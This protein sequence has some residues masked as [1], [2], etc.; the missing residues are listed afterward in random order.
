MGGEEEE[1]C[2]LEQELQIKNHWKDLLRE[3]GLS[4]HHRAQAPCDC[5]PEAERN[6]KQQQEKDEDVTEWTRM[7]SHHRETHHK[8]REM[9]QAGD[10]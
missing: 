3:G 5:L 6:L 7:D 9:N 10:A 2:V 1:D 4:E 8:W